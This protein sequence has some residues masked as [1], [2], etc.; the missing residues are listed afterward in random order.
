MAMGMMAATAPQETAGMVK[1][2]VWITEAAATAP[3]STLPRA[4]ATR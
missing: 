2:G 1:W 4:R 3:K